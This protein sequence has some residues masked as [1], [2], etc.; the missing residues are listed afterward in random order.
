VLDKRSAPGITKDGVTVPK[1]S[2]RGQVREHGRPDGAGSGLE[3]K[4]MPGGTTT[5]P[6]SPCDRPRR[7]EYVAA[8]YRWTEAGVDSRR[9][10]RQ[11]IEKSREGEGSREVAQWHHIV[12]GTLRSQM[13]PEAMQKVA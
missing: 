1:R 6:S 9:R 11:A 2:A 5:P 8:A 12:D 13:M 4:T 7:R 10:G 3:T